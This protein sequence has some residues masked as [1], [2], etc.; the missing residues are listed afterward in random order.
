MKPIT[1]LTIATVT[2]FH[3]IRK[4][5]NLHTTHTDI[6]TTLF[7][8]LNPQIMKHFILS[9]V[10]LLFIGEPLMAQNAFSAVPLPTGTTID[11]R[12]KADLKV[13]NQNNIWIAFSGK[14]IGSTF[15]LSNIGLAKYDGN[16]WTTW[17]K[18][19]SA[20][21]TNY[22]TSLTFDGATLWI[23][24]KNG[25]IKKAGETYTAIN[26]S[27]S[28]I[29]SDS[30]N[31]VAVSGTVI[32]VATDNGVSSFNGT[33]WTNYSKPTH[34]I[35]DNKINT[36]EVD[37]S[38]TVWIGTN[39]GLSYLKNGVWNTFTKQNSA[40][41][42]D[43]INTLFAD[44]AGAMWIGTD[45]IIDSTTAYIGGCY[46]Y[47]DGQIQAAQ[48]LT[49]QCSISGMPL[50][51]YSYASNTSGYVYTQGRSYTT[52]FTNGP[53]TF[54]R[55]SKPVVNYTYPSNS[56]KTGTS[57]SGLLCAIQH[58]QNIVWA[59]QD[60]YADSLYFINMSAYTPPE[61]TSPMAMLNI[62]KVSTPILNRGDMFWNLQYGGY[63]VPKGSCKSALFASAL[64]M[65]GVTNG[66]IKVAAQ[67]YRQ[68]G[69]D[70]FPGPLT[71]GTATTTPEVQQKFDRVWRINRQSIEEFKVKFSDGKVTDGTYTVPENLMS[72]PAHGDW[73]NGYSKYLAPFVDVNAD[74]LYNP[75]N[76]DYPKIKGDQMLFWIFNDNGGIH[77]ETQGTPLGV[78]V[79]GSAYAYTC[80]DIKDNDSNT[81]LNYTTFY[82]FDVFNKSMETVDSIKYGIWTDVELGNYKDDYIGCNPKKNYAVGYNGD[83]N[84][85]GNNGYGLNPPAIGLA[86]LG[87]NTMSGF[88]YY[89]NDFSSVGNPGRPEHYWGFMNNRWKDGT[90][91]TYGGS[92]KG[93]TDTASFMYPGNNDRA[94]RPLWEETTNQPGDRR[95]LVNV[96]GGN[97]LLPGAV[98][99]IDYAIVF[100]RATTGGAKGSVNKV[101]ADIDKVR[102]WYAHQSFPGCLDLTMGLW[103][104]TNPVNAKIVVYPNPA[105]QSI[106]IQGNEL[107]S[108]AG[109][110]I[111]DI[112]GRK[113]WSGNAKET[114]SVLSLQ[115][116]VYFI[117]VTD[118]AQLYV[119]KFIKN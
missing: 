78:E 112:T 39:N 94:G 109:Y 110:R 18:D 5:I 98:Q 104:N 103:T 59:G 100:S 62:N 33:T 20:L 75:M 99:S 71:N 3:S 41:K 96:S 45:S 12:I 48:Q 22:L 67:T 58:N 74:G 113:L 23:G 81:A 37:K 57:L 44:Q 24:S 55:L 73:A 82:H 27:N 68:S 32:W 47:S 34:A 105:N 119:A 60:S 76:G 80:D 19:N 52:S 87:D 86:V 93:G 49:N 79:H 6:I 25:L 14:K 7:H 16:T 90:P 64:W 85:E 26:K 35:A 65:G 77:T 54:V 101:D 114:I 89:N 17:N 31:D 83:D 11:K 13:D 91:L 116:G 38:G 61:T 56:L 111:I 9:L 117:E 63:E 21:P 115:P 72:W 66:N 106:S 95:M 53:V 40:L 36:I 51:V 92:G 97:S 108:G 50:S 15:Y 28:G 46:K 69:G 1:T 107:S 88:M 2:D 30:V 29:I 10:S 43:K 118:G 4:R 70:Y 102:N 42:N 84:D 8:L